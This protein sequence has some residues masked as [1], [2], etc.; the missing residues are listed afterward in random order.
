MEQ[1]FDAARAQDIQNRDTNCGMQ[2]GGRH[3]P[4]LPLF[5]LGSSSEVESRS[6]GGDGR[7]S[8]GFL[9]LF[10]LGPSGTSTQNET[11]LEPK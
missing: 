4:T 7:G 2:Q 1:P 3:D 10:Q 8:V 5:M 6:R 9:R 11:A